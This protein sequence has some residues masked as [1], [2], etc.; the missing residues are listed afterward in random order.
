[1][2][3][4][5][6]TGTDKEGKK[7][8]ATIEAA[9]RFAVYDVARQSEHTIISVSESSRLSSNGVPLMDRINA[10]I[11][12]V[13]QDEIVMFT[14]NLS[15]M[16]TAGLPMSRALSVAERQSKNQKFKQTM[17][18]VNEKLNQG[19]AFHDAVALFPNIFSRLYISMVRAG[20]EGG[21][22]AAA[23]NILAIQMERSS[24]LKKKIKGAMIYP[25]IVVIVMTMI[26]VLM[27]IY[28][29][30]TLTKTFRELGADLPT[31]TRIIMGISDLFAHHALLV[32]VGMVG[33]VVGFTAALRTK[34]GS[35]VFEWILLRLPVIG[36]MAKETNSARTARTL[37][38]LLA[39]GVDV[40]S[41]ISITEEVVQNSFYKTVLRSAAERVEKGSPLS[42]AFIEREDLYPVLVGEMIAV[43]EETGQISKML[44]QLAVF[45]EN[46]VEQKTK[47]LSTIIE[48][49]L[50]VVIGGAVGFFALAMIS[51]IYSISDSIG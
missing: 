1:M 51:P 4:F 39:S 13:K 7:V 17:R 41:A 37:S 26:G 20:E 33:A 30:P 15:A 49:V 19:V 31:S 38:S 21:T 28:V 27:M 11:G 22:L 35:K 32:L 45:Y 43:G 10:V 3:K 2:T 25:A 8:S 48:P 9:D 16:L 44:E 34:Y 23:L 5:T 29:I 6:Y 36:V 46:E 24:N 42:G 14:R 12:S 47:D 50:M 40:V 18:T